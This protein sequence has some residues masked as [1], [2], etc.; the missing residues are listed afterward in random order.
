MNELFFFEFLSL[1][2]NLDIEAKFEKNRL[3]RV[4]MGEGWERGKK[5][6]G[7]RISVISTL[8]CSIVVICPPHGEGALAK[9]SIT[10]YYLGK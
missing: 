9:T 8:V 3:F 5:M 4:D 10:F 7:D 6:G 1:S 2:S